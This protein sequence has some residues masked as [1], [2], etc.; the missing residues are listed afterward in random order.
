MMTARTIESLYRRLE[1]ARELVAAGKVFPVAGMDALYVVQNGDGNAFY[2]VTPESSC[3]CPDF[4]K[5]DGRIPCK[6][7]LA[8]DLYQ[9]QQAQATAQEAPAPRRRPRREPEPDFANPPINLD[10]MIG[11]LMEESA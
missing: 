11:S 1:R 7:L 8:V 3:T 4:E 2:L 10:A 6:H 9:Q 5:H